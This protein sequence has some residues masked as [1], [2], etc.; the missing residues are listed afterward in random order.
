MRT[1]PM[2]RTRITMVGAACVAALAAGACKKASTPETA[3]AGAPSAAETTTTGMAPAETSMAA[4]ATLTDANIVALLDEAN[5]ADSAAGA[6]AVGKAKDPGVRAFAKMMMG[7]HHMLRL[8]G[9]KLAKKLN[10]TPELPASDPLKP[11]ASA[12]MDSLKAAGTGSRFDRTYIDQEIGIHKAVLDVAK[13][14]HDQTQNAELK[15]LIEKAQPVIEKH[16]NKAEE[17]QKTLGKT[18]A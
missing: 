11:A 3:R 14:G 13:Q 5:M 1:N 12:E 18:A 15:A 8:E 16:L 10:I 17:L 4:H 7:E 2:R 6:F 9:Q